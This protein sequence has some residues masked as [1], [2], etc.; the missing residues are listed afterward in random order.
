MRR[1]GVFLLDPA[2]DKPQADDHA[3]AERKV[4]KDPEEQADAAGFRFQ[5]DPFAVFRYKK[6]F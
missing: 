5:Q 1:L 2:A 6:V 3:G 4:R